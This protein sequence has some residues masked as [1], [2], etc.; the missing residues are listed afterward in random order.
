MSNR[1]QGLHHY[2]KLATAA[3]HSNLERL[4]A[5]RGY[6]DSREG[7]I[8]YLRRFLAFHEEAERYLD[9]GLAG[10]F[11]PDWSDRRRAHLARLDLATL[12][13][14]DAVPVALSS[15]LLP[16]LSGVEQVL[17]VAYVLEGSTLGGAFLLRQLAPLGISAAHGGAYLGSYGNERG[18]MWQLFLTTLEAAHARRVHAESVASAALSAFNAARYYLTEAPIID[19]ARGTATFAD[20]QATGRARSMM[21]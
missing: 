4:L 12:G 9:A 5:T 17:G 7:Y 3:A 13:A 21:A 6:F 11:I 2:L 20:S 19:V 15:G 14:K 10:H 1:A 18:R 16:R 8:D